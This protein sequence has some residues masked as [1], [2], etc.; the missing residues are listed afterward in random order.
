ME[1]TELMVGE[2]VNRLRAGRISNHRPEGE[3]RRV[4]DERMLW[5]GNA[6]MRFAHILTINSVLSIAAEIRLQSHHVVGFPM[7]NRPSMTWRDGA[8]E[9][10]HS[11]EWCKPTQCGTPPTPPT[12]GPAVAVLKYGSPNHIERHCV[13]GI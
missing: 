11:N 2:G 9:F 5:K 10:P 1:R 7:V 12:R 13:K 3:S 6:L 4:I 8:S